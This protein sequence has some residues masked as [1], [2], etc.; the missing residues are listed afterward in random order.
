M[1][2][3]VVA[4]VPGGSIVISA[5]AS[6][7][8]GTVNCTGCDAIYVTNTSATLYVGVRAGVGAQT[9]SLTTDALVPPMGQII[10]PANEATTGVAAIGSAGGPTIVGFSPI[11]RGQSV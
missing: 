2:S 3:N 10:L 8:A 1:L 11:K 9:A 5:T 7:V 4:A 6:S